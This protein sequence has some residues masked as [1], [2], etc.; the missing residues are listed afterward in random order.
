MKDTSSEFVRLWTC[1]QSE[2]R[3]YVFMMVSRPVDAE[4]VVQEVSVK[5]WN[6]FEKYDHSLPFVPWAIRF[7]YYEVLKWRQR[8]A[9]EKLVFSEPLLQQISKRYE[10]EAPVM[11][12]R[13]KAL[14]D[15]LGKLTQQ[16]KKWVDLRY[17][18]HGALKEE[19]GHLGLSL[20]KLY[21]ALEKIRGKLLECINR[22]MKQEGWG[23]A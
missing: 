6:K 8:Q 13:N 17:G 18:K 15:C 22:K 2:V 16:E 12:A 9:R 10:E 5:L 14:E 19:A 7:A 4:E 11:E 21:Y 20:P 1:H 3:R 23:D